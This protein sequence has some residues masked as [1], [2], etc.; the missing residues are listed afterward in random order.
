V[1]HHSVYSLRWHL[2]LT[3]CLG[4][5]QT[6][7]LLISDFPRLLLN[8]LLLSRVTLSVLSYMCV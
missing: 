5:F 1:C 4:W 2:T 8:N 7:S 6:T 3:F